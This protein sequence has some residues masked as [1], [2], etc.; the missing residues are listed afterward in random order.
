M[1]NEKLGCSENVIAVLKKANSDRTKVI[2]NKPTRW[3]KF[4]YKIKQEV[5][6]ND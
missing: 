5:R 1:P 6:T 4:Y 3:Q 2:T